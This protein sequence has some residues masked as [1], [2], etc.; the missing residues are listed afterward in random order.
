MLTL[1]ERFRY[2]SPAQT[3]EILAAWGNPPGQK[4]LGMIVPAG[5]S[6]LTPEGWGVIITYDADGYVKDDDA[7]TIDYDK[8]LRDMQEATREENKDREKGGY[9]TFELAGWAEPPHYDP[10]SHKLFW[11]KELR[12]DQGSTLNYNIRVLGRKG[13]LVL[14]AV[15]AMD[16]IESVRR[17]MTQVLSFAEFN[18]GNRYADFT[19]GADH[20]AEY[21]I[22]ALVAGGIAAKAGL[23][24]GLIALLIAGKK[25]L[26]VAVVA[27]GAWLRKIFG[28]KTEPAAA[29]PATPAR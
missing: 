18:P 12:S 9:S 13:V 24:K 6:P 21:G 10:A 7:A 14:N 19:P 22:A 29:T 11:A 15:A 1:P 25:L 4:T 17:D 26:V 3:G 2:V 5:T 27:I 20:V 28:K 23:F 8:L 16:Q